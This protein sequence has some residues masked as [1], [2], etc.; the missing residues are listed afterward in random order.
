LLYDKPWM[1]FERISACLQVD[2][3][4]IAELRCVRD[5]TDLFELAKTIDGDYFNFEEAFTWVNSL[6]NCGRL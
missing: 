4:K 5:P 3:F 1:L 2:P 6:W